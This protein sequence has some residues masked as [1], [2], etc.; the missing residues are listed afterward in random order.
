MFFAA[1]HTIPP[2]HL[3]E[4]FLNFLNQTI[5]NIIPFQQKE[6]LFSSLQ[7]LNP[8]AQLQLLLPTSYNSFLPLKI[9]PARLQHRPVDKSQL[10]A[11]YEAVSAGNHQPPLLK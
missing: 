6:H 8:Q 5:C 9:Q 3:T 10:R 1:Q 11:A 7:P 2:R 4:I